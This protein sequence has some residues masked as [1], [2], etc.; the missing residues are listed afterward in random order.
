[1]CRFEGKNPKNSIVRLFLIGRGSINIRQRIFWTQVGLD[2][3]NDT[4]PST[5]F[6]PSFPSRGFV[7]LHI[8]LLFF[9]QLL[10]YHLPHLHNQLEEAGVAPVVYATPWFITLF[11]YKNPLHV[12]WFSERSIG[13]PL[14]SAAYDIWMKKSVQFRAKKHFSNHT[15]WWVRNPPANHLLGVQK[16]TCENWF[17]KKIH[18]NWCRI[19]SNRMMKDSSEKI[20][21]PKNEGMSP[22]KGPFF[23]RKFHHPTFQFSAERN[24]FLPW[25]DPGTRDKGLKSTWIHEC[26]TGML[27]MMFLGWWQI[28]WGHSSILDVTIKGQK[29]LKQY[30]TQKK[31]FLTNRK[32]YTAAKPHYFSSQQKKTQE[33][34]T[35][36]L[37]DSCTLGFTFSD[38]NTNKKTAMRW[39][40]DYGTNTSVVEIP[41]LFP[42]WL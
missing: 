5:N 19:S 40:W 38:T 10:L 18:I 8:T 27:V 22:E 32:V 34:F 21:L 29:L 31:C 9:R 25:F 41:P 16:N 35:T 12:T 37:A 2:K 30:Q 3:M 28:F 1:M 7:I 4:L 15:V 26:I 24:V 36:I 42:S 23:S 6:S 14:N 13:G 39:P 33:S 20:I 17:D 11:A